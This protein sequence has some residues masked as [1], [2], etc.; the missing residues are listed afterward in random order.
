LSDAAVQNVLRRAA[1]SGSALD[2]FSV[3]DFSCV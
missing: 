3:L 2:C 1:P